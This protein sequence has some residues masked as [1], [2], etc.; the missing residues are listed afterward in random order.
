M[1]FHVGMVRKIGELQN[2]RENLRGFPVNS[3]NPK[4]MVQISSSTHNNALMRE[5]ETELTRLDGGAL[6]ICGRPVFS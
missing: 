3:L 4:N 5:Y 6:N 2:L 1:C